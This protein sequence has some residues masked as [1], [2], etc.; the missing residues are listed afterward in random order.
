MRAPWDEVKALQ[1]ALPDDA[2]KIVVRGAERYDAKRRLRQFLVQHGLD[3]W[4]AAP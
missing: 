3:V 4:D 2:L 1:R